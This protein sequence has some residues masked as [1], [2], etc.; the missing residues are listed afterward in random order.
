MLYH[1]T[2]DIEKL[3]KGITDTEKQF[4]DCLQ[5]IKAL[6]EEKE[7]RQKELEDLRVAARQ[8][9]EVPDLL[10]DSATD[11]RSLLERLRGAPQKVLSFI[12]EASTTYVSHALG[13]VKLFWPK[14]RLEV[15]AQGVA[16]DYSE[17]Q[18]SEYLLEARPIA[19]KIVESIEQD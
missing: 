12:T 14:A 9:V 16:A 5:Q 13:L 2:H 19:E 8:L 1:C 6:G 10:E 3:Q 17:E 11:G 15:L 7:R 18:F 4:V